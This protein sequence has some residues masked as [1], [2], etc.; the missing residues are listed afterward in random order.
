[1]TDDD[2]GGI[3][4]EA[5]GLEMQ[6]MLRHVVE[7]VA[8]LFRPDGEGTLIGGPEGIRVVPA[9]AIKSCPFIGGIA[10]LP[11]HRWGKGIGLTRRLL[12]LAQEAA[13]DR[14]LRGEHGRRDFVARIVADAAIVVGAA[15]IVVGYERAGGE[16][17]RDA[18]ALGL[19]RPHHEESLGFKAVMR[20]FDSEEDE[21]KT[22]PPVRPESRS[23]TPPAS[24]SR[25]HRIRPAP[26]GA[27][28]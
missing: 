25:G 22:W 24:C 10:R 13:A 2:H 7:L 20:S 15:P 12:R 9:V 3:G 6:F 1:M 18:V 8:L 28:Q 4:V 14:P 19:G 16:Q 26:H 17:K 21:I 23:P 27:A 11:E 5:V